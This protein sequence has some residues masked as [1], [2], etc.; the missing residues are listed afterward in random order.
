MGIIELIL[1]LILFVL[2]ANIFFSFIP[3]PRGI[4]GTLIAIIILIFIWRLVF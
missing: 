3:L 1:G 4:L 2:L